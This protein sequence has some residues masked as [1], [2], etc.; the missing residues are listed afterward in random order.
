MLD[1]GKTGLAYPKMTFADLDRE[2][3]EPADEHCLR[4]PKALS[5]RI[6]LKKCMNSRITPWFL[7]KIRHIVR[8]EQQL[9]NTVCRISCFAAQAKRSGFSDRQIAQ[10]TKRTEMEVRQHRKLGALHRSLNR[11]IHWPPNAG[12]NQLCVFDL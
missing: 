7:H 9:A 3:R 1:I 12:Q 4:L 10:L 6:R 11:L 5:T 2:I 8:L